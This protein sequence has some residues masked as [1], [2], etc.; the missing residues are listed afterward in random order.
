MARWNAAVAAKAPSNALDLDYPN[1][2]FR[3]DGSTVNSHSAYRTLG[4]VMGLPVRDFPAVLEPGIENRMTSPA[5]IAEMRVKGYPILDARARR[6]GGDYA[7][8]PNGGLALPPRPRNDLLGQTASAVD[9]LEATLGRVPDESS[10]RL[11]Y[12]LATLAR[13]EGFERVEHV[14]LSVATDRLR[15]RENVFV[16]Q[17]DL[18]A[19][20]SRVAHMRSA[21]PTTPPSPHAVAQ[22]RPDAVSTPAMGSPSPQAAD[23]EHAAPRL[24]RA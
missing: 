5:H 22:L 21:D 16:V 2:G 14:V 20:H 9:R 7:P 13:R 19:P 4:E 8:L 11:A 6:E 23:P 18:H 3:M 24:A 10:D 17:G 1:Y 12:T 15:A